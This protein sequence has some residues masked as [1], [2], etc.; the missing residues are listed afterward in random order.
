[1]TLREWPLRRLVLVW[2]GCLFLTLLL[3]LAGTLLDAAGDAALGL[4]LFLL[5]SVAVAAPLI[6]TWHWR[7]DRRGS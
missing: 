4:L 3:M 7:K 1:M 5:A 6:L 2:V